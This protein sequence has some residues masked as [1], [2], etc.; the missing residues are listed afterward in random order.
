MDARSD[1]SLARRSAGLRPAHGRR[2]SRRR[3]RPPTTTPSLIETLDAEARA[4]LRAR[5][6]RPR[7]RSSPPAS[8][9]CRRRNCAQWSRAC[10]S[11]ATKPGWAWR[12][13]RSTC[14]RAP[15]RPTSRASCPASPSATTASA[16]AG[17]CAEIAG[18]WRL[19]HPPRVLPVGCASSSA[20]S[21][22]ARLSKS[23]R[24]RPSPSSPT[25][26]RCRR[27]AIEVHPRR[28]VR[29]GAAPA[30][31]PQARP[32]LRPRRVRARPAAALRHDR[33]SSSARFRPREARRPAAQARVR[34]GMR[35]VSDVRRAECGGLA[36]A[37]LA[38]C[39][40]HRRSADREI[41][42]GSA[43]YSVAVQ[44]DAG[45]RT[46]QDLVRSP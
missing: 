44:R 39:S 35:R 41:R 45:P 2:R 34:G 46:P 6:R 7:R 14:Q 11:F 13:S 16:A 38:S 21:C 29:A 5:P 25:S 24:S 1:S 3:M 37:P 28:A 18:G 15:R 8:P 36:E 4:E 9:T 22:S 17:S 30:H 31:G 42:A 19:L 27:G 26:S 23:A 12:A 20:A 32:G 33:R 43:S 10:S 40:T